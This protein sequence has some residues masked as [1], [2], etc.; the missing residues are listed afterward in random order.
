MR[1]N[2]RQLRGKISKSDKIQEGADDVAHP[3]MGKRFTSEGECAAQ[4][5]L[6][7]LL[8]KQ[9]NNLFNDCAGV[10]CF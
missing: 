1:G 9:E 3:V 5:E 6:L 10:V 4:I 2:S 8:N 7:L